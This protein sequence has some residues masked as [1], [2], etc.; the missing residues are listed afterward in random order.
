MDVNDN[1]KKRFEKE[2]DREQSMSAELGGV[3]MN[4]GLKAI[5]LRDNVPSGRFPANLIHDGSEEVRECFPDTKTNSTGE[6]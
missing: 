6:K 2:W 4:K 5:S 1:G 3:A